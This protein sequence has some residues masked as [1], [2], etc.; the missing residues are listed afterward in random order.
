MSLSVL[1]LKPCAKDV[2]AF[3]THVYNH[4]I[5]INTQILS[6][7]KILI[8]IINIRNILGL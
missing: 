8:I 2:L 1:K 7:A 3:Q 6:Q 4:I 5:F